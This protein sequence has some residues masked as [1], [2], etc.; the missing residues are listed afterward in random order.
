MYEILWID[1]Q[2]KDPRM[3]EF[4][5]EAEN[6][7]LML[8][9]YTSFE[10]G[11]EALERNIDFYDVILLDGLFFEKKEQEVGTEDEVGIGMAIAK[12]NELKN[13]KVFPWFVLSG[14]DKFT[15]VEN[16]LLK[17]NNV[18]CFDKTN[19]NDITE[20]F[21]VIKTAA[22]DQPDIQLKHKYNQLLET[23][24]NEFLGEE[25]YARLFKL[26][27]DIENPEKISY[28]EDLLNLIRKIIERIFIRM[29][30][31]GIIP[32][33]IISN[34]GWINGSS[35][36]LANKH[37][38]YEQ[39]EV[40]TPK[41]ISENIHRL[42]NII[43]DASHGEGDLK[44]K[45]DQYLRST[46]T[47]YLYRSCVYLLFDIIFWF[48]DLV[49][50]NK[51]VEANKSNW[52]RKENNDKWIMGTVIQIAENGWGTFLP[53]NDINTISIPPDMVKFNE[54]IKEQKI[55]ITTKPSPCGTKTYIKEI[56]KEI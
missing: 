48:K 7:G 6:K 24:T 38:E 56:S 50:N 53:D 27:K 14:K 11:F 55:T 51:D 34:R 28:T 35:L 20:L 52:K 46:Q 54:I 19:R 3:K 10:E 5:I 25:Q 17:A 30:E 47:D 9:G 1:D 26:I 23:C 36:F 44:L 4:T 22:A 21:K 18:R 39:L 49:S 8:H 40:I 32:D 16:S 43:Q 2:Y 42:L 37:L 45:V 33:D 12:I 13:R 29:S 41:V 15:K 31:L